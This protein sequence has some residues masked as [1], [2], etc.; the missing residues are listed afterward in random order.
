MGAHSMIRTALFCL[1]FWSWPPFASTS[2][3]LGDDRP[4]P[5]LTSQDC[6][7]LLEI[8]DPGGLFSTVA[9]WPIWQHPNLKKF[10]TLYDEVFHDEDSLPNADE[11]RSRVSAIGHLIRKTNRITFVCED[12]TKPTEWVVAIEV[13]NDQSLQLKPLIVEVVDFVKELDSIV[14][15]GEFAFSSAKAESV[16]TFAD[17]KLLLICGSNSVATDW[18]NRVLSGNMGGKPLSN[19]RRFQT[20][21]S[22]TRSSKSDAIFYA[23][24]DF[25]RNWFSFGRREEMWE[26]MLPAEMIGVGGL[27]AF[28]PAHLEHTGPQ[29]VCLIEMRA[30]FTAPRSGYGAL[31]DCYSAIGALPPLVVDAER[32]SV[33]S[34]DQMAFWRVIR[35]IDE[36]IE[37]DE[38]SYEKEYLE[39]FKSY[40]PEMHE[41]ILHRYDTSISVYYPEPN[42]RSSYLMNLE[43]ANAKIDYNAY[44]MKTVELFQNGQVPVRE[45]QCDFGRLFGR[46]PEDF[47]RYW[48][49]LDDDEFKR[50]NPSNEA[51]FWATPWFIYGNLEDVERQGKAL[52]GDRGLVLRPIVLEL[53]RIHRSGDRGATFRIVA[54]T[55]EEQNR[56]CEDRIRELLGQR[57]WSEEAIDS[58]WFKLAQPIEA[59][60]VKQVG[61]ILL[62]QLLADLLGNYVMTHELT[63]NGLIARFSIFHV[64][65]R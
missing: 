25:F 28:Q 54:A 24:S 11:I 29:R 10:E 30:G 43:K 64:P 15:F 17:H 8:N 51:L 14:D 22:F 41:T 19:S 65:E 38:I 13:S 44:F 31:L 20:V 45:L 46:L 52:N 50:R 62:D 57:V 35:Q 33:V 63:E 36:E 47:R 1:I 21:T 55:S 16:L 56:S 40:P 5:S 37:G 3:L 60:K 6:V 39:R 48:K 61:N 23:T 34:V 2:V 53:I 32:I 42:G 49:S 9:K 26:A 12:W 27:L 7:F 59:S 58:D 4:I 18:T